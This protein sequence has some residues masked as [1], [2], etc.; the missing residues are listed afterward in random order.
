M[1]QRASAR[2]GRRVAFVGGDVSSKA[3]QVRSFLAHQPRIA[4]GDP[5]WA[6]RRRH[7][8]AVRARLL[9]QGRSAEGAGGILCAMAAMTT[10]AIDDEICESNR[11]WASACG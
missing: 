7:T 8:L 10:D 9:E 4:D 11:G 1:R 3:E 2:F 5:D 6:S